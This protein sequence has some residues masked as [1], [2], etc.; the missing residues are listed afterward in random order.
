MVLNELSGEFGSVEVLAVSGSFIQMTSQS[1]VASAMRVDADGA[2]RT[3]KMLCSTAC[4]VIVSTCIKM[5]YIRNTGTIYVR[6]CG[7]RSLPT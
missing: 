3:P 5:Q 1:I 2:L 4:Q 7:P 6:I